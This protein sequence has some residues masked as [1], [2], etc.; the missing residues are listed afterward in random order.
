MCEGRLPTLL[1][2]CSKISFRFSS[3]VSKIFNF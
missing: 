1:T 2:E 3:S